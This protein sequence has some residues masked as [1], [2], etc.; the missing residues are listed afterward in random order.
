M[1]C[2][3]VTDADFAEKLAKSGAV[4]LQKKRDINGADAWFFDVS[5]VSFDIGDAVQGGKAFFSDRVSIAF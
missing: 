2:L 5:K 3:C 1:R 4:M